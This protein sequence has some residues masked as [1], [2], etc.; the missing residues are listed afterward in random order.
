[1]ADHARAV[2][3]SWPYRCNQCSL[4]FWAAERRKP[5]VTTARQPSSRASSGSG[6]NCHGE[7]GLNFRSYAQS[8][9]TTRTAEN[10]PQIA[11][12]THISKPQAKIVL[13]ADSHEQLDHLLLALN[14][15]IVSYQPQGQ[16]HLERDTADVEES[17]FAES[18]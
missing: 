14:R 17:L 1:M 12:R 9:G 3:G 11:F 13:Q 10:N 5:A 8:A 15:A 2:L 4:R 16:E 18:E 7:T 6:E